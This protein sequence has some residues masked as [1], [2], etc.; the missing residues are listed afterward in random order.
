MMNYGSLHTEFVE[1]KHNGHIHGC[2]TPIFVVY[3]SA[4]ININKQIL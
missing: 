1:A 3:V 2:G 4:P